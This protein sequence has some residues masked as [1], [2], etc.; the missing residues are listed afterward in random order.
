VDYSADR[1][2]VGTEELDKVGMTVAR[3]KEEREVVF[4]CEV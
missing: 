2:R 4:R 1:R 3:M